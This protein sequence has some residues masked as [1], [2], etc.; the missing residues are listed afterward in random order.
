MDQIVQL[1]AVIL[2][3]LVG[4]WL[5][6]VLFI[7]RSTK[8]GYRESPAIK[9]CAEGCLEMVIEGCFP[10]FAIV[11]LILLVAIPIVVVLLALGVIRISDLFK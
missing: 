8:S 9:G 6:K 4:V 7:G 2:L 5:F 11:F 1:V 3:G 10:I